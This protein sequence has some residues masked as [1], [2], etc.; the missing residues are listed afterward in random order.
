MVYSV[1]M[2]LC[3]DKSLQKYSFYCPVIHFIFRFALRFDKMIWKADIIIFEKANM[4]NTNL[5]SNKWQLSEL[6]SENQ[7]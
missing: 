5:N 3:L 4:E 7:R 1:F 2:F 6:N